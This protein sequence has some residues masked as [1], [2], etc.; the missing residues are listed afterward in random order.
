VVFYLA[1]QERLPT[2]PGEHLAQRLVRIT[3]Q[4]V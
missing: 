4:Q 1:A 2:S 3:S